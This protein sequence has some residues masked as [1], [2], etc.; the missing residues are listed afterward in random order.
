MNKVST[1]R[2]KYI[3]DSS[4]L[5]LQSIILLAS[6]VPASKPIIKLKKKIKDVRYPYSPNNSTE[7]FFDKNN[8]NKNFNINEKNLIEVT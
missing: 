4:D 6:S 2:L 3:A 5:D 7:I 8:I 1:M